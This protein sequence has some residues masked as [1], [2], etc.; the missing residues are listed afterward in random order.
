MLQREMKIFFQCTDAG[1][2][3]VVAVV[4]LRIPVWE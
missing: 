1:L 4:I 2:H 3:N